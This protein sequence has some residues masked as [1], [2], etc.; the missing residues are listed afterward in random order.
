MDEPHITSFYTTFTLYIHHI[1]HIVSP[2][3]SIHSRQMAA[4][5]CPLGAAHGK[6]AFHYNLCY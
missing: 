3:L 4:C 6:I 2:L 5:L 1:G